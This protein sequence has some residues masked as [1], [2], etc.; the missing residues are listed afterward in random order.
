ML[1]LLAAAMLSQAPITLQAVV[2]T[3]GTNAE[4]LLDGKSDTGW[5]PEGDSE[6]EGVLFRFEGEVTLNRVMVESC[7]GKRTALTAFV[8]GSQLGAV[9]VQG[10]KTPA[11]VMNAG[12]VHSVFLRLDDRGP[13]ACLSEVTFETAKP[14]DVRAPRALA[15]TAKAS[16]VLAPADAYHPGYLF[17]GRLDFGWVEGVK[18][19]GIGESMALTFAAPVTVTALELWNGYQRSDDHFKKNA[20][21]K[22]I[23]VTVDGAEPV[24]FTLKDAQGSQK[25][26]L[27]KPASTKSL[28]LTIKEAYPGSKYDDLVL[29][30]LRLWDAEGP[31][32][33]STGDLADRAT[34]LKA[35]LGQGPLKGFVDRT[36]RSGCQLAGYELE[37][38]FRTNHSFVIYRS[39]NEE[40]TGEVKEVLDGTWIL[41]DGK[42]VELFGRSHRTESASGPYASPKET[43]T[44]SIIGGPLKVT[45]VGDLKKAEYEALL[46]KFTTGPLR[47]SFDCDEL[48]N[49]AKLSSDGAYVIEGRALTAI[50]VP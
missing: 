3:S 19:P 20:R 2:P 37:A 45:R 32:A 14:L 24:E 22:K 40:E 10:K 49:F 17:D 43:D 41:K 15:A 33:I 39:S 34:A 36:L 23:A 46:A 48:K 47:W 9:T 8:N 16:S 42:T 31:R 7:G 1:E 4:A 11:A 27:P 38:K 35:E 28:T 18:G 25:L 21:A 29:S 30:E 13:G 44:T 26:A 5:T 12:K 50:L 6:G